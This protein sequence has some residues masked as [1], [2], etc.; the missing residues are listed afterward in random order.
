MKNVIP[1]KLKDAKYRFWRNITITDVLIIAVWVGLTIMFIFGFQ[2]KLWIK[3]LS[4]SIMILISLPLIITNKKT[5][6]KGWQ[7]LYYKINYLFSCKKYSKNKTSLLVPYNKV[8]TNNFITTHGILKGT[9][10]KTLIGG[11]QIKGFD[12]TLLSG[13]EQIIRLRDLQDIFKFAN[14][15]ITLLKL[16]LP[17]NFDDNIKYLQKQINKTQIRYKDKEIS[18]N[19]FVKITKQIKNNINF[20]KKELIKI[21]DEIKTEKCF[22]LFVYG[23]SEQDLNEKILFLEDK[24]YK[25][26]INCNILSNYEITKILKLMWNPHEKPLNKTDFNKNKDNLAKLLQFNYLNIKKNYF[27]AND[28]Y[29]SINTIQDYPLFINDLWGACLFSN[30]QTIIWNINPLNY[31]ET[32]KAINSAIQT[33]QT[34][35]VMTKSYVNTNENNYELETY[36]HLIDEVNGGGELLKNVNILFLNYG[37]N[38]KTLSQAQVRLTKALKEMDIKVNPLWYQQFN[39]LKGFI[40][41]NNKI[42]IKK[43]G[44][45]MPTS[46]LAA[47]F[48]FID[49]GLYDKKGAWLGTN[50]MGNVVLWDQFKITSKRTNHNMFI[51]GTAGMGKSFTMKKMINHHIKMGRKVIVIDPEREYQ[52]LCKYYD[53]NWIDAGDASIG[54]INPLQI[55]DNNFI[56]DVE[57]ANSSP[58]SNHLRFLEQWFKTLYPDFNGREINLL[59]KYLKLL[60]HQF[61]IT[62]NSEINKI[63]NIDFP[64]MSD[65]YDLLEKEYKNNKNQLLKEFMDLITTDFLNDGKY[66]ALWNGHTTIKFKNNFVVYD[67]YNLFDLDDKK[68]NAAQLILMLN[69]I[70]KEVKENRFKDDNEIVII[71]DEAH[72][73]ID[74]DN[75]VAL[76][77]MYQMTKRIRK[78]NGALV[79]ATQN[80]ADF[81]E[82]ETVLKK[83]TAIINNSQYSFIMG[84]KPNDLEKVINLYKSYGGLTSAEKDYIARSVKGQGLFFVSGFERYRIE[85]QAN[86]KE[87]AGFGKKDN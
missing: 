81:V 48:P 71:V 11:I 47:S 62:N 31:D 86:K 27:I 19:Q 75:P 2:W 54:K 42:I 22:F 9:L 41:Y 44:R 61:N 13:E 55:L 68:T 82:N 70:K 77:F 64:I 72:L 3:L 24:L 6:L 14:F 21:N 39:G 78:Y 7:C 76:N 33:T 17:L 57:N 8:I 80:I 29:Y 16:E 1:K 46:T 49:S 58:L 63:N 43:Y 4:S 74:K 52:E 20:L 83:T 53:G 23:N 38:K 69:I 59:T 36:Y 79:V 65:F 40:P 60:Y 87:K 30:E 66:Q 15:P 25:G 10:K 18:F 51:L 50:N 85:I 35:Q 12:I 56:D 73:A 37:T 26:K 45:E 32:K 84:L 28:L 5:N 67:V 34:R